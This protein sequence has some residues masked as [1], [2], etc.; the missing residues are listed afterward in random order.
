MA[1][2]R[3]LHG[4]GTAISDVDVRWI[5]DALPEL[6]TLHLNDTN[7][8]DAALAPLARLRALGTLT[9]W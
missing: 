2:P 7:I 6:G 3:H 1:R 5:A 9:F 8:T 4:D